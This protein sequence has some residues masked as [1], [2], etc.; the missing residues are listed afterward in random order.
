MV[1]AVQIVC[2]YAKDI[3]QLFVPSYSCGFGVLNP[4]SRFPPF[5]FPNARAVILNGPS[6][7]LSFEYSTNAVAATHY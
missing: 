6:I 5:N 3:L 1:W 7:A 4:Y 2:R